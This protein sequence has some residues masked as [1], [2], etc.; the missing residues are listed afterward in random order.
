MDPIA[1]SFVQLKNALKTSK[2]E[3]TISYSK[4]KLAILETLKK[5]GFILDC[6]EVKN[7]TQKYPIIQVSLKYK[8][9]REGAFD[10]IRR[11]SRPGRRVY[12]PS[13]KIGQAQRGKLD[14]I[15]STP[16]GVMS[17]KEARAKGLGGEVI[18]EVV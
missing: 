18:G 10:N 4:M 16:Q 5:Q 1:D 8:N 12:L 7:E 14:I 6:Q 3:I 11:V 2:K 9:D 17:G 15:I 13:N